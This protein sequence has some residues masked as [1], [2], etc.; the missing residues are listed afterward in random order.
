MFLGCIACIPFLVISHSQDAERNMCVFS[1]RIHFPD[2]NL[3]DFL[4]RLI[5]IEEHVLDTNAGKQ[6]SKSATGV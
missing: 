1:Q 4:I 3:A 5:S 6:L 2:Y